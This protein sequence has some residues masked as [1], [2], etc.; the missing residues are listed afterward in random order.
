MLLFR[1]PE[2]DWDVPFDEEKMLSCLYDLF[3][4]NSS[5]SEGDIFDTPFGKFRC[6]GVEVVPVEDQV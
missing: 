5:L 2:G 3:Q 1:Y 4:C 6:Q